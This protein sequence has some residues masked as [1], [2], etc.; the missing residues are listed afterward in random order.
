MYPRF[1]FCTANSGI[2]SCYWKKQHFCMIH[3]SIFAMYLPPSIQPSKLNWFFGVDICR[4]RNHNKIRIR[5]SSLCIHPRF[6]ADL[7]FFDVIIQN[8]RLPVVVLG[9]QSRNRQTN[10]APWCQDRGKNFL[11]KIAKNKPYKAFR[12]FWTNLSLV[13]L[14]SLFYFQ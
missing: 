1:A 5:I 13:G 8:R 9:K 11:E 4:G 7:D 6:Q 10:I 3:L 2:F 14:Y 12:Q